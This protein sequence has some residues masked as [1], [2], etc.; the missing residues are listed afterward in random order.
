M[1]K[2]NTSVKQQRILE[3]EEPV[4]VSICH[5]VHEVGRPCSF[6]DMVS[7]DAIFTV[8]GVWDRDFGL[9]AATYAKYW[10]TFFVFSVFPAPD[11]PVQRMLWSSRSIYTEDMS[12]SVALSKEYKQRQINSH[13]RFASIAFGETRDAKQLLISFI[14]KSWYEL[15]IRDKV[16]ARKSSWAAFLCL[17]RAYAQFFRPANFG[18]ES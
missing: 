12:V 9:E 4:Q 8:D 5:E 18:R 10:M 7:M 2:C 14:S 11:S 3:Y 6:C 17:L 13:L 1:L 15:P 16:N